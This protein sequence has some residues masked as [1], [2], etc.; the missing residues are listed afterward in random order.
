MKYK[1]QGKN[2][3]LEQLARQVSVEN[4]RNHEIPS[5]SPKFDSSDRNRGVLLRNGEVGFIVSKKD[6]KL[7]ISKCNKEP[8]FESPINSQ[9]AGIFKMTPIRNK[10][11]DIDE[12]AKKLLVIPYQDQYLGIAL[13][14]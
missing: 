3:V 13:V 10:E 6:Q 11:V 4:E 14:N 5:F 9:S 8:F 12:I 1:L 7:T 2:K